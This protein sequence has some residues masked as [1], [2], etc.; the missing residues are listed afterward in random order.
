MEVEILRDNYSHTIKKQDAW[1]VYTL[2]DKCF[3]CRPN[4]IQFVGDKIILKLK[5]TRRT[6]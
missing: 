6:K 4:G 3:V 5:S 1:L 2:Q